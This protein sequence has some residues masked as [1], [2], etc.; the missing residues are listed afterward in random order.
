[1]NFLAH[2]YLSGEDEKLLVG[3]FIADFV[4]GKTALD[5]F[6]PEVK[7]GIALHRAID[8]FTDIH[9]TVSLSKNRLREKY[10][11]Y[12][13]VII[14]V[15]YDHFL[16]KN[17]EDYHFQPLELYASHVYRII[18]EHH[19]MLPDTVKDFFP[20]MVRGNWLLNYSKVEGISR[21]L[22][23][24]SRRTPYE[25]K[26]DQAPDELVRFYAEF[27]SEFRSF[28]PELQK[29]VGSF[30]DNQQVD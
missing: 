4:K 15:F 5:K 19:P 26:M 13:A 3:N 20:Y 18:D 6:D 12:S 21:A 25:S 9:P 8:S 28:F 24:M 27:E 22:T 7:K 10:R 29:H 30:L 16:A 14:D 17:W 2:A 1:M 11:H 23:G